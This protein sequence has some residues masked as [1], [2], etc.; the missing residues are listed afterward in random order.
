MAIAYTALLYAHPAMKE[1]K[2]SKIQILGW[3]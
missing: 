3:W 2:T 1:E